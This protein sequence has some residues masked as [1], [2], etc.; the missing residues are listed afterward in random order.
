[1]FPKPNLPRAIVPLKNNGGL[2]GE[3]KKVDHVRA[4]APFK[5]MHIKRQKG[6]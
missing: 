2:I 6:F 4:T 1:M 3:A 5:P